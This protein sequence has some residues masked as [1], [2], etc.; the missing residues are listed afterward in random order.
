MSKKIDFKKLRAVLLVAVIVSVY[1]VISFLPE[2]PYLTVNGKEVSEGI[3]CYYLDKLMSEQGDVS[4][5]SGEK[6]QKIRTSALELTSKTVIGAELVADK[7]LSTAYKRLAADDTEKLWS[8][9]GDYYK[10]VSVSKQDITEIM[11]YEY[12][13]KQLVG[14]YYGEGT[15][16]APSE[17][18]LKQAFVEMYVG[19]KAVEGSLMKD[20]DMGERVEISSAEKKQLISTFES[21]AKK[22]NS[23][24]M[25]IDEANERYNDT[26]GII[27]M[28]PLEV[29]LVREGDPLYA[30]DFFSEVMDIDHGDCAVIESGSTV[31]L[32][33]RQTIATTD[34]D[35]FALYRSEILEHLKMGEIEKLIN[36][37]L[38][39]SEK[40]TDEKR[41]DE[42]FR[43]I[44]DIHTSK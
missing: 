11:R 10:T 41:A 7:G 38:G 16:K 44:Y 6:L 23:G 15:E 25:T 17:M 28:S 26:L 34:E 14:Q 30:E 12:T 24:D 37:K 9:Y 21:L 22:I 36:K 31:Y 4:S 43:E 1:A 19:F 3:Y 20:S 40:V 35:A 2:K 32:L 13:K 39:S 33:Q 27:V 5:L 18:D 29:T 42:I 8:L